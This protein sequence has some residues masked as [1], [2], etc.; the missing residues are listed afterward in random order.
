VAE[1]GVAVIAGVVEGEEAS[2]SLGFLIL[3]YGGYYGNI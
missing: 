1:E 3:S 2:F